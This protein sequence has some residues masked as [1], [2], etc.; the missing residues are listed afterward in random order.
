MATQSLQS[1]RNGCMSYY[2]SGR[3]QISCNVWTEFGC[4]RFCVWLCLH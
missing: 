3:T 4:R 2:L 1:D